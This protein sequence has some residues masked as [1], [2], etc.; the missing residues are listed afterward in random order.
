MKIIR[1]DE[2]EYVPASHEDLNYPGVLKK[3]L[4]QGGDFING[5]LRM[6]NWALLPA[7][8]AFKAHFHEDMQEIFVIVK[9]SA[10]IIVDH[11]SDT[12]HR[13]D[14]VE[15]QPGSTHIMKNSGSEDVEYIALGIS[16]GEGGRTV[17]A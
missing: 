8:R 3:V 4:L 1:F 13:G 7:G 10:E 15:I 17:L 16:R 6:L 14:A 2:K 9:G 5:E 11:E 12:L